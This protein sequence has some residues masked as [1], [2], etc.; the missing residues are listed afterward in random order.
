ML[1]IRALAVL[2]ALLLAAGSAAAAG[3]AVKGAAVF[4][5]CKACHTIAAGGPNRIGPN[6]HGLFDR[7]MGKQTGFHYS[8]GLASAQAKWDDQKLDKWLTS[9]QGFIAG[10]RMPFHLA[11]SADRANVI[12]YLHKAAETR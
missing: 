8:S 1:V 2:A 5:R 6:L 3:D 7:D 10:A 9:P 4:N 12:A 11:N